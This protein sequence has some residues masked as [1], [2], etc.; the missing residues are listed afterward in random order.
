MAILG[1][2]QIGVFAVVS[3]S[4]AAYFGSCHLVL[5][6]VRSPAAELIPPSLGLQLSI[7]QGCRM[8]KALLGVEQGNARV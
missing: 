4:D 7:L 6:A 8:G 1:S 3:S 5:A 2:F